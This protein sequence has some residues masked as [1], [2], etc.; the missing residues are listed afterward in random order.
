MAW[1]QRGEKREELE[2]GAES[3]LVL[4]GEGRRIWQS[5]RPMPRCGVIQ[6]NGEHKVPK[7][8]DECCGRASALVKWATFQNWTG[9][10]WGRRR[11]FKLL[12]DTVVHMPGPQRQVGVHE[13]S[14]DLGIIQE[15][16]VRFAT[17]DARNKMLQ[18]DVES[19]LQLLHL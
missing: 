2:V 17:M 8:P 4:L 13:T 1:K 12:V 6:S 16:L 19:L 14:V 5:C 3:L 7:G 15:L 18:H 10:R 9:T 11:F